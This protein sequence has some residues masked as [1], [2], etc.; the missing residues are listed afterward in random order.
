M[1]AMTRRTGT[2][3]D[4]DGIRRCAWKLPFVAL[5]GAVALAV[6]APSASAQPRCRADLDCW[7][8][9][10]YKRVDGLSITADVYRRK[11]AT[12]LPAVILIHGGGWETGDKVW[13]ANSSRYLAS[14]GFL[15][16][17]VNYRTSECGADKN[18]NFPLVGTAHYGDHYA[19]VRDALLWV[20]RVGHS[21]GRDGGRIG[22][23]GTSAGGHLAMLL[24][25]RGTPGLDRADGAVSWGAPFVFD[26][27]FFGASEDLLID[28]SPAVIGCP[29]GSSREC[30]NRWMEQSVTT[31][32][33]SGDPPSR[34]VHAVDDPIVVIEQHALVLDGVLTERGVAHE[35]KLWERGESCTDGSRPVGG[36]CPRRTTDCGATHTSF[37]GC[38]NHFATGLS[39]REAMVALFRRALAG[40]PPDTTPPALTV[41]SVVTVN[42]TGPTG[43]TVIFAVSATDNADPNPE[44][45]CDSP[46]GSTFSVGTA[47]VTCTATDAAGNTSIRT[48]EVVVK[49]AARQLADLVALVGSFGLD[50]GAGRSFTAKLDAANAALRAG[51]PQDA[52]GPL[53]AVI[54]HARAQSGKKLT[55]G[56]ANRLTADATR[57]RAVLGC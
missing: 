28:R 48:F 42:A 25:H 51:R 23:F 26:L 38:R 5:L 24:N 35:L 20:R 45:T 22:A 41:P 33:D 55:V 27:R 14:Q 39:E 49:G 34:I 4:G 3:A 50:R 40:A 21:F 12:E 13:M 37:G 43:A 19:D 36:R 30:T 1:A 31:Y 6:G 16:V 54:N 57:I 56:Q 10:V 53:Q 11:G 18:C 29:W 2:R 32:V 44:V 9:Q 8:D 46:S 47:R 17:N 15:A 52:C 7:F